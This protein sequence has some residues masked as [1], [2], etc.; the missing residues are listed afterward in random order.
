[1]FSL[2]A[3]T[4]VYTGSQPVWWD[5]YSRIKMKTNEKPPE[6]N[7]DLDESDRLNK[8]D[9]DE[10]TVKVGIDERMCI[11]FFGTVLIY[12]QSKNEICRMYFYGF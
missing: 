11:M 12:L 2:I 4:I 8:L 1:M 9:E 5:S 10:Y 3:S 7:D 6:L